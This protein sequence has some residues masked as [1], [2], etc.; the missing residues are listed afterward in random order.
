MSVLDPG[1]PALP[2]KMDQTGPARQFLDNN[3]SLVIFQLVLFMCTLSL[4][5]QASKS[6]SPDV[7]VLK[8]SQVLPASQATPS[9]VIQPLPTA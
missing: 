7:L 3:Q 6:A 9:T 4:P 1:S 5:F 8:G 2:G